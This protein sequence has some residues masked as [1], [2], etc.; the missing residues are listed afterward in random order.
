MDAASVENGASIGFGFWAVD[1]VRSLPV[2]HRN[3]LARFGFQK[4][5]TLDTIVRLPNWAASLNGEDTKHS[6]RSGEEITDPKPS[7]K[8]SNRAAFDSLIGEFDS[9]SG[10]SIIE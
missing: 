1:Q 8:G 6:S 5:L 7:R 3:L 9:H 2:T 4:Y 10:T